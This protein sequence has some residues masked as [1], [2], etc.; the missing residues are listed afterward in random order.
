MTKNTILKLFC[1]LNKYLDGDAPDGTRLYLT[2]DIFDVN[3]W[4]FEVLWYGKHDFKVIFA[5][6]CQDTDLQVFSGAVMYTTI[7]LILMFWPFLINQQFL[8]CFYT[9]WQFFKPL[10]LF[11]GFLCD[12]N[13]KKRQNYHTHYQI[14]SIEMHS[15]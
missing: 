7:Y 15:V 11:L 8:P 1:D 3:I 5:I 4:V 2:F 10:Y 6:W 13:N 12:F 14:S 9:F